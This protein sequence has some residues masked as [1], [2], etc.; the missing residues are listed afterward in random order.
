MKIQIKGDFI[1]LGQLIKKLN[2]I[3]TGGQSKYFIETHSIKIEGRENLR[4]NSKI[5][6]GTTIWIDDNVFYIINQEKEGI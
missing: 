3:D 4:R 5:F 6:A 2:I 1:K